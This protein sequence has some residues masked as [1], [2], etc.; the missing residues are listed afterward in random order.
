MSAATGA[1]HSRMSPA[2][3]VTCAAHSGSSRHRFCS[4]TTALAFLS[5]AY[6]LIGTPVSAEAAS[7]A[8]TSGPRPAPS[9]I[10]TAGAAA[11]AV[12]AWRSRS[13]AA[14]AA[15]YCLYLWGK[16]PTPSVNLA[17]VLCGPC[18]RRT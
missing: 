10:T 12:A 7:E 1:S 5:T 16:C 17:E 14:T 3:T 11:L 6:A 18:C 8:A 4:V 2:H 9:T 15:W 13:A